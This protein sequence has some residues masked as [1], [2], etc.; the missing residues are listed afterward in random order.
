MR[1]RVGQEPDPQY[2]YTESTHNA[3]AFSVWLSILIGII[4]L[5]LGVKG[6]VLWMIVWSAGLILISIF[7][8]INQYFF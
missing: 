5:I 7:Y 2:P 3:L 4:L 8:L 1:Y 6:R